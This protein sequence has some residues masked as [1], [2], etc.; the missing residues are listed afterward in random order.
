M[1]SELSP[2][3][4]ENDFT[5]ETQRSQRESAEEKFEVRMKN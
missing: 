2:R 4:T 1:E 3:D 5:T